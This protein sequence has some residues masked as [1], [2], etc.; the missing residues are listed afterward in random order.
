MF[1]EADE[2][3]GDVVVAEEDG[4]MACIFCGYEVRGLEGLESAEGDVVEVTYGC[5]DDGEHGLP[6][7]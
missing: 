5:R 3:C 1:V 4:G 6:A 2:G 7:F